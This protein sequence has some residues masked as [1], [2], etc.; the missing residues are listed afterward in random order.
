MRMQLPC[1]ARAA[2]FPEFSSPHARGC[3]DDAGVLCCGLG[4]PSALIARSR[5]TMAGAPGL[6]EAGVGVG[7]EAADRGS[8]S[9]ESSSNSCSVADSLVT[10]SRFALAPGLPPPDARGR[11]DITG[12]VICRRYQ[13]SAPC[14][15][16]PPCL[17]GPVYQEDAGVK[18]ASGL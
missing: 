12:A 8:A 6:G 7:V 1:A 14:A 11:C 5:Y 4:R 2:P 17:R 15:C 9:P 10:L 16:P 13:H 3:R 18:T